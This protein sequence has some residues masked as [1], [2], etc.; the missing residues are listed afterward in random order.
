MPVNYVVPLLSSHNLRHTMCVF[1]LSRSKRGRKQAASAQ[2]AEKAGVCKKIR[3]EH[4]NTERSAA[5]SAVPIC[6]YIY[7][8]ASIVLADSLNSAH[9]KFGIAADH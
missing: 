8:N 1:A 9:S 5:G 4:R 7:L 3:Q 2:A 6:V